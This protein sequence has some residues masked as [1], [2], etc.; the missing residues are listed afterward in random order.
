MA[1]TVDT[2]SAG[3]PPA[4][5]F[6]D[7]GDYV[8]VGIVNVEDV[9]SRNYDTGDP[10]F[11]GDGNPKMHPRITG[12]VIGHKGATVGK[13]DEERAVE[14]GE[15]VTIY[16]QG[17]RL[18]AWREAKKAHGAVKVGDVLRWKF[19][20][21][22]PA[23]NPRHAPRKVFVGTLRSPR[24]D[25]GDLVQRCEAAYHDRAERVPVD[26]GGNAVEEPF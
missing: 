24:G 21:T 17:G 26:A 18:Y 6:G 10:E 12:I 16:A 4:V 13:D 9:Q 14:A 19:D 11:W 2:P 3:G 25:D 15:I 8:D 22:E 20:R 23:R 5:K 1:I 7:V